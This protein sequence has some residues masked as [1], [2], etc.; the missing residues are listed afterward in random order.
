MIHPPVF[1][2]E[3]RNTAF[4]MVERRPTR[5]RVIIGLNTEKGKE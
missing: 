2:G 1:R 5:N 3:D 4:R